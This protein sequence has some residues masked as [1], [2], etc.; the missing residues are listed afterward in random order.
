MML[1]L[2]DVKEKLSFNYGLTSS[3]PFLMMKHVQKHQYYISIQVV[4]LILVRQVELAVM[5]V[6]KI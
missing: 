5:V 2:M 6:Y 1:H 4:L 3:N